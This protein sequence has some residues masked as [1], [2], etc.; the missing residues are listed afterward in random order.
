VEEEKGEKKKFLN[1][2]LLLILI[3]FE[4]SLLLRLSF[5]GAESAP[6]T[7]YVFLEPYLIRGNDRHHKH[8]VIQNIFSQSVIFHFMLKEI[9]IG[10]WKKT[11]F[12]SQSPST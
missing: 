6:L 5:R 3:I 8:Y 1:W 11:C 7:V 9:M 2:F 12:S 4:I 10:D